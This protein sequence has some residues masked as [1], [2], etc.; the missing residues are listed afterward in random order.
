[1]SLQ[2]QL[3]VRN[4]IQA[5]KQSFQDINEWLTDVKRSAAPVSA[6]AV[7]I[8]EVEKLKE[9][10]NE[11]TRSRNWNAACKC[12]TAAIEMMA[13]T[14]GHD[15]L[16]RALVTNRSLCFLKLQRYADCIKD[17]DKS[18]IWSRSAKALFRKAC[19]ETELQRWDAARSDLQNCLT[20][21]RDD[22]DM[23]TLIQQ[24]QEILRKAEQNAEDQEAAFARHA[25]CTRLPPWSSKGEDE[26]LRSL[27]ING[28]AT[29]NETQKHT[30]PTTSEP[31]IPRS[32]R[33]C[34]ATRANP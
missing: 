21:I 4:R 25:L 9:Q 33:M 22:P 23:I 8:G 16:R 31:Y 27:E 34:G 28:I 10:G 7:D 24:Q 6:N 15:A 20:L 26:E 12:Y 32:V 19:A 2:A 1:M 5:N 14:G 3:E 29:P 11:Y 13:R 30:L 17:C 18:L